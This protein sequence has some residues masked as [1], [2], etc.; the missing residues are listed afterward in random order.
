MANCGMT[1]VDVSNLRDDEVDWAAGRITRKRSK[2]ADCE[3]TPEVCYKLWPLTFELLKQYRSGSERVLLTESGK[4]FVRKD[5]VEGKLVKADGFASNYAH[6]KKKLRKSLPGFKRSLKQLRKLGA[7]LLEGHKDHGRFV[8][9]FL[10][11]SPR[12]VKDRHY[13]VPPQSLFDEAVAWLGEQLG[14]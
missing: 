6:L 9:Y 1:Q 14:Q 5:L 12:T 2:T 8:S 4:P 13:A 3:N 7:S 10:G 11:H